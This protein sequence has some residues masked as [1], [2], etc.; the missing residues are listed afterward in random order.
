[1]TFN[2]LIA[3]IAL[4]VSAS[5]CHKSKPYTVVVPESMDHIFQRL[6]PKALVTS[7]DAAQGITLHGH[8]GTR[9]VIPANAFMLADGSIV[10]GTIDL[11]IKECLTPADMIFAHH[12]TQLSSN[13]AYSS[14]EVSVTA[15]KNSQELLVWNNTKIRLQIPQNGSNEQQLVTTKG[16]Q[17]NYMNNNRYAWW[18]WLATG[19]PDTVNTVND[20]V[21]INTSTT[22]WNSA[23][24]AIDPVSYKE[25]TL[26]VTLPITGSIVPKSFEFN[27]FFIAK[28]HKMVWPL[29]GSSLLWFP[30]SNSVSIPEVPGTIVVFGTAVDSFYSGTAEVNVGTLHIATKAGTPEAFKTLLLSL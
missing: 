20:T 13:P 17:L 23:M 8:S 18:G 25:L 10:K 19:N 6:A 1:M 3:A 26:D 22:G 7:F 15:Y 11:E 21:T 27:A 24:K 28:G 16:F 2:R 29:G 12:F 5:S 9:V 30:G 4:A 14:G